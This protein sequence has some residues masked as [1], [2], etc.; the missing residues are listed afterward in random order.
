MELDAADIPDSIHPLRSKSYQVQ[1]FILKMAITDEALLHAIVA[2]SMI[3][4]F[5]FG[6]GVLPSDAEKIK[7]A[8]SNPEVL[9][10]QTKVIHLVNRKLTLGE[11][12][13]V[14]IAAVLI[15]LWHHVSFSST[16]FWT[17]HSLEMLTAGQPWIEGAGEHEILIHSTGLK[18]MV[19]CRGGL[20]NL[21]EA[22]SNSII[23]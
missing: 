5:C 22:L 3:H 16:S 17:S 1:N 6:T 21:P 12:D 2:Y 19:Q 18:Q 14:T 20:E 13:D 23:L 15:L 11:V 10:H 8:T 4:R 9:D 7:Y